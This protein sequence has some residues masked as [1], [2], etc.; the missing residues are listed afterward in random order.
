[1][2]GVGA[3]E[4]MSSAGV[5]SWDGNAESKSLDITANVADDLVNRATRGDRTQYRLQFDTVSANNQYD[6]TNFSKD[7]LE[8]S[9]VYIAD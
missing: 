7:T 5:F 3:V 4:A 2:T 6:R 1:M 8:M 9:L